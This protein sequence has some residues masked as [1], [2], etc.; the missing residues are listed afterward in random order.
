V[1]VGGGVTV[2]QRFFPVHSQFT[3]TGDHDCQTW[4]GDHD[5]QTRAG[6]HGYHVRTGDR[7]VKMLVISINNKLTVFYETKTVFLLEMFFIFKFWNL[8][9]SVV[10]TKRPVYQ[11]SRY[12]NWSAASHMSCPALKIGALGQP[13]KIFRPPETRRYRTI[14]PKTRVVAHF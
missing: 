7:V 4:T 11:P 9:N 3:R 1:S 10:C 13:L 14:L 5:Y 12:T 2:G 6:D 8:N